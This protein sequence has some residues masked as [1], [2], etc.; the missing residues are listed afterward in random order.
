MEIKIKSERLEELEDIE[1]RMLALEAG[2]VDNWEGYGIS[3]EGYRKQK[4]KAEEISD[5]INEV[6]EALCEGVEEPAGSGCGFGVT[7]S[8]IDDAERILATF[9]KERMQ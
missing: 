4:E 6:I 5:I 1:N 3:L 2:G 7:P 8:C 9:I